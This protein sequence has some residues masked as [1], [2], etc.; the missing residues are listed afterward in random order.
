MFPFQAPDLR[1]CLLD[2]LIYTLRQSVLTSHDGLYVAEWC[3]R[4]QNNCLI[5]ITNMITESIEMFIKHYHRIFIA[6]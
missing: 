1:V 6:T 2:Y 5:C 3:L 4:V